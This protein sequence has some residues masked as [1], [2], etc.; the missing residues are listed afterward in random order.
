MEGAAD[1]AVEVDLTNTQ[2]GA[3]GKKKAE[4]RRVDYIIK[5]QTQEHQ[6]ALTLVQT[7]FNSPEF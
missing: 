6:A 1:G 7:L 5:I 3:D 2:E 4:E